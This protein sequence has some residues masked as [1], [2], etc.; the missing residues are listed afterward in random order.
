MTTPP[1][2]AVAPIPFLG[3]KLN[4]GVVRGHMLTFYLACYATI[5]LATF[6]PATQP[7]LLDQVLGME[8][9]RQGVASGNLNFWGEIVIIVTVGLWGG[10]SDRFGRRAVTSMGFALIAAGALL[11][12]LARDI[13]GLYL[14]RGVY[15]A[16][17][18]AVSTML[19]TL[20]ADY[21]SN[22]SRGKATGLLGVMNGLGAMT[23]ALF[24]LRL[25]AI[26]QGRGFSA[27]QSAIATY[28]LMAAIT[29]LIALAMYFGL[30]R[31]QAHSSDERAPILRQLREG[32]AEARRPLIALAYASSFV[33]RG[34]LAVVGT[35]F[36]LWASVYGT[37]EL[38]MS[39][40]EAVSKGG[41]V[42]A[43]SYAASLISAPVFGIMTDRLNRTT[44]LAVTLAIGAVGYGSTYFVDDPFSLGTI[45]CLILI[46]MA[47]V[48][49]IITSGVLIAEQAPDRLRGSIVGLFTLSGAIGILIA[50]VVGGYLFDHWLKTG[51]FV[52]FGAISALVCVWAIAVRMRHA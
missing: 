36:T 33:A 30:R 44:A 28:G 4:E 29:A 21:V 46:G 34:N 3:M 2:A 42:V 20:M 10:L 15:A 23:A 43:I 12:G 49:C 48:G 50:S 39:A 38:G 26:F 16:G 35:F 7:F 9:S 51:P 27:E 8:R 52:F 14:A 5:M 6:V 25:P 22:N 32:I 18:A 40:A 47:E 24:L 1:L 31:G 37:Q 41:A 45:A 13:G 19:I 17:I 11:Y